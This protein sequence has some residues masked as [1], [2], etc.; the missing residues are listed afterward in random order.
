MTPFL[1]HMPSEDSQCA[2]HVWRP[3][4]HSLVSFGRELSL[5]LGA[6]LWGFNRAHSQKD[7]SRW[8]SGGDS[9]EQQVPWTR[10]SVFTSVKTLRVLARSFSW[11]RGWWMSDSQAY[12]TWLDFKNRAVFTSS[13]LADMYS[14]GHCTEGSCVCGH[15][16]CS[17]WLRK[18]HNRPVLL[19]ILMLLP[20]VSSLHSVW[21]NTC[22]FHLWLARDVY[23][24]NT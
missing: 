6:A 18:Q 11:S 10:V 13:I 1:P 17:L 24:H 20:V 3:A 15:V 21:D 8:Y 7:P 14:S 9:G 23:F 16:T 5:T 12:C 2:F 19:K 22:S 4:S